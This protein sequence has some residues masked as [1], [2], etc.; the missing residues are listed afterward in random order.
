VGGKGDRLLQV[1][2]RHADG[3]N[4]AWIWTQDAW[5]RRAAVLDAACEEAGRDPA[6]VARSVGL[7]ALAGEDDDDL[8]ARFERLRQR[9]PD[10]VMDGVDLAEW[11]KGRL[12]GTVA[13]VREQVAAWQELGVSSLVLTAGAVPFALASDDDVELLATACR[14]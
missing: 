14:V 8:M 10:G 11:R 6:S 3:W 1:V 12:V 7:Y 13:E 5:R 2:A 9:S 4:T